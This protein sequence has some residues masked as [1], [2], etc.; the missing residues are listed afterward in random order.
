MQVSDQ[1]F[2]A[3]K[4]LF[5]PLL[6]DFDEKNIEIVRKVRYLSQQ[7]QQNAMIQYD[8]DILQS[9]FYSFL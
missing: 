2:P 5:A 8:I 6:D 1:G 4:R 3:I 9:L 7:H